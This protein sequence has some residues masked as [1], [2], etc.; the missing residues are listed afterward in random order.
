V[1]GTAIALKLL[2]GLPLML[3]VLVTVFDVLL[4]LWLQQRGFASSRRS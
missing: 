2:F 1:I 3:G 4:V